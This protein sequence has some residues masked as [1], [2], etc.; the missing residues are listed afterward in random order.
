MR[1]SLQDVFRRHF[2]AYAEKRALHPRERRAAW[3]IRGCYRPEMGAHM[4]SCPQ[5]HGSH[6][7]YHACRHRCCPKCAHGP[8]QRWLAAQLPKLLP[9]P[10]FHVVFTLPHELLA[11][12]ERNRSRMAKVL[13]DAA[14]TSVLDLMGDARHLGAMPGVLMALHT[15]GRNLSHHPHVHCLVTAG[16][17]D[18]DGQWQATREKF[19]LPLQVL[20]TLF[21]GRVLGAVQQGLAD[22]SLQLPGGAAQAQWAAQYRQLWRSHWNIQINAPY[23]HGRGVAMYLARYA[24][25]GPLGSDRRLQLKDDRVAFSY[26]DHHDGQRKNMTLDSDAFIARVLWHAPPKGQHTVRH[27][28]LYATARDLQHRLA[29][30]Q[31]APFVPPP[32]LKTMA[33]PVPTTPAAALLEAKPPRC[34]TC[35]MTLQRRF[36]PPEMHQDGENSKDSVRRPRRQGPTRRCNGHLTARRPTPP[37]AEAARGAPGCQMPLS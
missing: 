33:S 28:G 30:R 18:K 16:G 17:L 8:R 34:P 15:W 21:R 13:F 3:S 12:W 37:P 31:L 4:L 32:P 10:H 24:K 36:L 6:V 20:R 1:A 25:G 5:G 35:S 29:L 23:E 22:R 7:Q 27:A 19:L 26:L 2:D 9:C 11:M 14:R